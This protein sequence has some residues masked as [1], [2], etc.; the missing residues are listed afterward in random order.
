[1]KEETYLD[2]ISSSLVGY[3]TSTVDFPEVG[4]AFLIRL[5]FRCR[6]EGEIKLSKEHSKWEFFGIDEMD[7]IDIA[8]GLVIED[9]KN[10]IRQDPKA[11]SSR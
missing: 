6:T 3:L 1:M 5:I 10:L 7:S 8:E 2:M 4:A 11:S 9:F